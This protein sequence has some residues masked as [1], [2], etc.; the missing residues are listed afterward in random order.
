MNGRQMNQKLSQRHVG[1]VAR[2]DRTPKRLF[3]DTAVR[4]Q[5]RQH[6]MVV[7]LYLYVMNGLKLIK[8]SRMF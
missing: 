3:V 6:L 8:Y 2:L 4:I 1:V 5:R 7:Q